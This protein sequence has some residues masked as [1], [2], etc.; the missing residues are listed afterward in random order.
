VEDAPAE[1]PVS[2]AEANSPYVDLAVRFERA[3]V[4]EAAIS[5]P[6]ILSGEVDEL[7][8]LEYIPLAVLEE[9]LVS[10]KTLLIP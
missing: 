5:T 6:N 2:E 7:V 8:T 1:A 3:P 9:S 10:V 4:F